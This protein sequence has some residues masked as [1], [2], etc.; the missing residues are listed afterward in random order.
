MTDEDSPEYKI[1]IQH[2]TTTLAFQFQGGVV[3]AVDSRATMGN[4][5]GTA[6]S[7]IPLSYSYAYAYSYSYVP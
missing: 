1:K 4:Y 6:L 2:G 7:S 5:I 3:V